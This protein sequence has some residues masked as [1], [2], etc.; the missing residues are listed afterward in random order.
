MIRPGGASIARRCLKKN[1]YEGS[2]GGAGT[3][4][5]GS[6]VVAVGEK[7]GKKH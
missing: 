3:K 2:I 5:L 7:G 6:G 4:T 1:V